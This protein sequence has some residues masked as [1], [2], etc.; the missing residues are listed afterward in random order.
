MSEL[1]LTALEFAIGEIGKGEEGENNAG[2]TVEKYL[3]GLAEPPANWCSAFVCWCYL[4]AAN[5]LQIKMPFRYTL[6][7]RNLFNQFKAGRGLC[8]V[9]IPEPG[10]LMFLWRESPD[11]WM[12]HVAMIEKRDDA[13]NYVVEGNIGRFP[14]MVKR[15][16]YPLNPTNLLGFGRVK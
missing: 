14:S 12:G 8:L 5:K 16:Y 11:S 4:Q 2:P 7:A 13:L 6:S 9:E 10:D 3:D 1:A 15:S